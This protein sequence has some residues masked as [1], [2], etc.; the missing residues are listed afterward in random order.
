MTRMTKGMLTNIH[1]AL[2]LALTRLASLAIPQAI[3]SA[4]T[5]STHAAMVITTAWIDM[6]MH[7]SESVLL[8]YYKSYV[9]ER[10]AVEKRRDSYGQPCARACSLAQD[11]RAAWSRRSRAPIRRNGLIH[12][13]Q[14][15]DL[16][17]RDLGVHGTVLRRWVQECAVKGLRRVWDG[18]SN[19]SCHLC[20]RN[21]LRAL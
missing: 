21:P 9:Y 2:D 14:Y 6:S 8:S 12:L 7:H 11:S 15:T 20:P 10:R 19:K 3:T 1:L 5:V 13:F 16:A 4:S 17:S 18:E